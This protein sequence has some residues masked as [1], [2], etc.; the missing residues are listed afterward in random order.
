MFRILSQTFQKRREK[1]QITRKC[2]INQGKRWVPASFSI[3]GKQDGSP[4]PPHSRE[5]LWPRG[6]KRTSRNPINYSQS[7]QDAAV[8]RNRA[9]CRAPRLQSRDCEDAATARTSRTGCRYLSFGTVTQVVVNQGPPVLLCLLGICISCLLA[10]VALGDIRQRKAQQSFWNN[11]IL[12]GPGHRREPK[13]P[14]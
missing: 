7:S 10:M 14:T 5:T 11:G 4:L 6:G 9:S 3:S 1:H 13:N 8:V 12:R 2:L